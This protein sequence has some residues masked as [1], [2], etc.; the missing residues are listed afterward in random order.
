M[1]TDGAAGD[2]M[3][4]IDE[5]NAETAR[6]AFHAHLLDKATAARMKYGLYIDTE[7][8]L[9]MLDDREVVRHP[10]SIVFDALGHPPSIPLEKG[11]RS[12]GA[13]RNSVS[14]VNSLKSTTKSGSLPKALFQAG[15]ESKLI[16]VAFN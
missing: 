8:I 1:V 7:A 6:H 13:L 11:P 5:I 9:K 12:S 2:G 14:T 15:R 4:P 16:V 3:P 10:T